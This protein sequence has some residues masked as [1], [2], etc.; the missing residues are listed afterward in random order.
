M[1]TVQLKRLAIS[2]GVVVVVWIGL[3]LLRRSGTDQRAGF[4]A[5]TF[6]RS[7]VTTVVIGP[8]ED[9]VVL[10][11]VTGGWTVNGLPAASDL[12]ERLLSDLTDSAATGDLV[13]ESPSS[14][15]RLG[16]DSAGAKRVT[17]RSGDRVLVQYL[18]GNGGATWGTVYLRRENDAKVY[19]VTSGL[20]EAVSRALDDWRDKRILALATDSIGAVESSRGGSRY[21]VERSDSGWTVGRAPAD[22]AAVNRWLSQLGSLTASGFASAG[23]VDSADFDRPDR[24]LRIR[25]RAG[26]E[27]AALAFDSIA[28]GFLVRRDG[29]ATVFRIDSWTADR[30]VPSDSTLRARS[31]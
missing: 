27:V 24:T 5:T 14:H 30:V 8:P 20:T 19:Q 18:V 16:V 17:V 22:T 11:R 1:S 23:Q 4:E 26:R 10:T 3:S 2:L 31:N 7:T 15:G 21:G 13:A 12:V 28:G 29:S 25:D 9:S 6:D